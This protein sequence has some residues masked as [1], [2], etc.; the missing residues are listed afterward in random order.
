M[1]NL[2]KKIGFL[3]KD[4]SYKAWFSSLTESAWRVR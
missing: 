2:S 1:I 3:S 4:W